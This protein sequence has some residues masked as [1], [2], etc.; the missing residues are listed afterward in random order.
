MERTRSL[1]VLTLESRGHALS[2]SNGHIRHYIR[3]ELQLAFLIAWRAR[4]RIAVFVALLNYASEETR[5]SSAMDDKPR[6]RAR[7]RAD[8]GLIS[9]LRD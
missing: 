5:G 4:C 1:R 3:Y 8:P 2:K 7:S 6:A 9:V